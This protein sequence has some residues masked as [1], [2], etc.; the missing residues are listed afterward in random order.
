MDGVGITG[1]GKSLCAMKLAERING[2]IIS[3][4]SIQVYKKLDI[5]S[6]KPSVRD[7]EA[8]KHHLVDIRDVGQG[9][10][11]GQFYRDTKEA[12]EEICER[13]KRPIVVGGTMMYVQWLVHG[14][15]MAPAA[16]EGIR[17]K[18]DKMLEPYVVR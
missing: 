15:P 1:V 4:D 10:T 6:S 12:V 3:A 18:V 2:E 11:T 14:P 5:G 7:R 17:K 8:V 9:Y 16:D 13:G